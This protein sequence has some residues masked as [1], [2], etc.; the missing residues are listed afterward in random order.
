ME[1]VGRLPNGCMLYRKY[2]ASINVWEYWSDEVGGGVM[3]WQTGLVD[4]STLLTA[5]VAEETRRITEYHENQR[6]EHESNRD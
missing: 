2:D 5:I 1:Q 6:K 3:V 4:A